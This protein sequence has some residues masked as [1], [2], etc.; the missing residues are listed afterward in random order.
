MTTIGVVDAELRIGGVG[1]IEKDAKRA[2]K[3]LAGIATQLDAASAGFKRLAGVGAAAFAG[4][5]GA[6]WKATEAL[7]RQRE[8]ENR[9]AAAIR[10]SGEAI[11]V[12]KIKARAEA[13]AEMSTFGDEAI[14]SGAAMLESFKMTEN[15]LLAALPRLVDAAAFGGTSLENMAMVIGK[16]M[17]GSAGQLSRFGIVMDEA[18]KAIFNASGRAEKFSILMK[19][20]DSNTG[21]AAEAVGNTAVGAFKRA[22]NAAGDLMEEIGKLIET[23]M[24]EM[25]D[26]WAKSSRDVI[27]VLAQL[28]PGARELVVTIGK[29]ALVLGGATAALA[30]LALVLPSIVTGFGLMKA[31]I[32]AAGG[33]FSAAA[34]PLAAFAAAAVALG[35]VAAMLRKTWHDFGAAFVFEIQEMFEL[36]TIAVKGWARK[37]GEMFRAVVSAISR[38]V[39][40][41]LK[42]L[43]ELAFAFGMEDLAKSIAA[44]ADAPVEFGFLDDLAA[45]AAETAAF[46]GSEIKSGL[47]GFTAGLS[48]DAKQAMAG[49]ELI[50]RDIQGALFGGAGTA[51]PTATGS[52]APSGAG[53]PAAA[54]VAPAAVQAVQASTFDGVALIESTTAELVRAEERKLAALEMQIQAQ[55]A[56]TAKMA[57]KLGAAAQFIQGNVSGAVGKLASSLDPVSQVAVNFGMALFDASKGGKKMKEALGGIFQALA[58]ALSPIIELL[59]PFITILEI[60]V[61]AFKFLAKI[62]T[63]MAIGWMSIFRGVVAFFNGIFGGLSGLHSSIDQSIQNSRDSLNG[64]SE[65]A[66]NTAGNLERLNGAIGESLTNVPAGIKVARARFGATSEE[67]FDSRALDQRGGQSTT[68]NVSGVS[69]LADNPVEFLRELMD[70]VSDA[71]DNLATGLGDGFMGRP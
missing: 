13:L 46:V 57:G 9:L 55:E 1:K 41:M 60:L 70:M 29:W 35:T 42:Q 6:A 65:P 23:P 47:G 48:N 3:G 52:A 53:A 50:K 26:R 25:F 28:N 40:G 19:T 49:L 51:A 66:A 62:V 21:G 4:V 22:Q 18:D 17:S 43:G 16:A 63:H 37:V 27:A 61:P 54:Q 10:A 30:G 7:S 64:I 34:L 32:L 59:M 45:K 67:G 2:A 38:S 12:E 69:L 24:T 36:A 31:A 71:Q 11:D 20:L 39:R 33:A 68:V 56:A 14:I 44:F 8:A 5:A 58:N 15:E